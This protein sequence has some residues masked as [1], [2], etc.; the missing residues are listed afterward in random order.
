MNLGEMQFYYYLAIGGGVLLVLSVVAY[1]LPIKKIKIPAVLLSAVGGGAVGLMSGMVLMTLFGYKPD[2]E[3]KKEEDLVPIE[4]AKG[5]PVGMGG[6]MGKGGGMP[7]GGLPKGGP[8]GGGGA[9]KGN[10]GPSNKMLLTFL[11][12]ALDNVA[13]KPIHVKLTDEQ[14][15]AVL[16]QLKGLDAADDIKDDDAKA[17]LDAILKVLEPHKETLEAAGYRWPGAGGMGG[18]GGKN[19]E[20]ANPFKE[21]TS[22][23][24][25]KS[26]VERLE[27]KK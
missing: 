12:T 6:G 2:I 10:F 18:F 5:G 1:F 3:Q 8:M 21:G 16:E 11:V 14:R 13:E 27:K 22:A 7:K 15:S 19:K 23:T 24:R 20:A 4:Q 25:L 9:P 17:K 26:L